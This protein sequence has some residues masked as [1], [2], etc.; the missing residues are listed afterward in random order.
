MSREEL[1]KLLLKGLST[2]EISEILG[3]SRSNVGYWINKYELN[4]FMKHHSR[5]NAYNFEKIDN[6]QKAYSLGFILADSNINIKN[7]IELS[8]EKRDK[9]IIDFISNVIQSE[10][11][12]DNTFVKEKR[13]FPRVRTSRK[14][15]DILKFTG[16]RLKEERHYPKIKKDL[17]R[18][19]LL[20]FF[21]ADGC[22]TW[23]KRK[24]R[25][26][27]WYK[28]SFTSQLKLL[29][30]IQKMLYNNL[31]ISS[32]IRPKSNE[33]CYIIEISNKED[34]LKFINYIYPKDTDFIVLQRKYL[35]A[36]ALR[37]ELEEFGGSIKK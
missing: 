11:N 32:V 4:E 21:D 12:I 13:R 8:I 34:V 6:R 5:K 10:V 31:N 22:I 1:L 27:L 19:M 24:D 16:G 37:L 26:K 14:I 18:Y 20:G 9:E 2:R 15:K 35:K 3:C 29:E 28:I 23:G 17:E 33:N 7:I 36:N 25:N 30:G